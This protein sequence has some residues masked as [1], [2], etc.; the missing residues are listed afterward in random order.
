MD[1]EVNEAITKFRKSNVCL[2]SISLD[3]TVWVNFS[4]AIHPG[5]VEKLCPR[6][7]VWVKL[8]L[9]WGTTI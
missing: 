7:L 5:E 4:K 3:P 1:I 6:E 8:G 9:D 2:D